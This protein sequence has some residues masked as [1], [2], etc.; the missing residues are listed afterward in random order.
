MA[1]HHVDRSYIEILMTKPKLETTRDLAK[2][3]NAKDNKALI[4]QMAKLTKQNYVDG[5]ATGKNVEAIVDFGRWIA[6]CE[7]GG[8]EI[9]DPDTPEFFCYSCGNVDNKGRT[10]PVVFPKEFSEIESELIS[11]K[12]A[13]WKCWSSKQSLDELKVESAMLKEKEK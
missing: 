11:R 8:A 4:K 7:C 9:V 5:N 10:R 2:R 3:M 1:V 12:D 13:K 6:K